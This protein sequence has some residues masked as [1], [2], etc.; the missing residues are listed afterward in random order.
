MQLFNDIY[1]LHEA[2]HLIFTNLTPPSAI[3]TACFAFSLVGAHYGRIANPHTSHLD[4]AKVQTHN[5]V[6]FLAHLA[7][8]AFALLHCFP[9]MGWTLKIVQAVAVL[10]SFFYWT[11]GVGDRLCFVSDVQVVVETF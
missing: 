10:L 8:S 1:A 3:A 7:I 5:G 11:C 2:W 9:R 4:I 6:L